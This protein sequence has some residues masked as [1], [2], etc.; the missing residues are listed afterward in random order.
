MT[1]SPFWGGAPGPCTINASQ[2]LEEK[3]MRQVLALGKQPMGW[4]EILLET[5]AAASVPEAIIQP[6]SKPGTW[7]R[8]TCSA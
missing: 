4:Q 7:Y 5:G 6:W 1:M 2:S 8:Y 3:T